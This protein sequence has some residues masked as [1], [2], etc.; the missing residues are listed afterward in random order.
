MVERSLFQTFAAR[1]LPGI[2][3]VSRQSSVRLR[4]ERE[5]ETPRRGMACRCHSEQFVVDR[6]AFGRWIDAHIDDGCDVEG[7]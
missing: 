7:M 1:L 5:T 2:A 3:A 6:L 4:H